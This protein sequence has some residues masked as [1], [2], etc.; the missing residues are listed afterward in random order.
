[1][2]E[3]Y[4]SLFLF[5]RK[6]IKVATIEDKFTDTTSLPDGLLTQKEVHFYKKNYLGSKSAKIL[7]IIRIIRVALFKRRLMLVL[8]D[9]YSA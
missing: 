1:M 3:G 7:F 5:A 6:Y 4:D 8:E 9:F 2:T